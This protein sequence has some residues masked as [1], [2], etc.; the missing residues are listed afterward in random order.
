MSSNKISLKIKSLRGKA[1]LTQENLSRKADVKYTT[2]TKIES[3]VIKN[4]SV[5]IMVK[6]AKAL[7]VTV[8][9]L[10]K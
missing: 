10:I 3:G 7:E 4:P 6:I 9:E 2:L 8:E 1:K 5:Q